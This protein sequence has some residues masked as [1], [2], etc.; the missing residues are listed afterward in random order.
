MIMKNMKIFNRINLG[1]VTVMA[2][3]L[4]FLIFFLLGSVIYDGFL[5][6]QILFNL[7]IDN[8]HLLIVAVGASLVLISGGIDLSIGAVLAFGS[9]VTAKLLLVTSLPVAV[10]FLIVLFVGIAFGALN[11]FLIT[12]AKFPAFIATLATQYLARGSCYIL[13][14]NTIAVSNSALIKIS[15]Y[16]IRLFVGPKGPF[17]SI[18]VIVSLIVF[19]IFEII[20]KHTNFGRGIYALGGNEQSAVL[21]GL[22]TKRIKML[23]YMLCGATSGV[24]S[25]VFTIYMLSAF[26]LSAESLHL[27]AVSAAVIGGVLTTGGVGI[28][29]GTLFGV[30]TTGV[31]QTIITFQ[32]TLSS[33]WTRIITAVLLLAFILL[34]RFV[35]FQRERSKVTKKIQLLE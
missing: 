7:F 31:I 2:A 30:L 19:V 6:T 5:S 25:I 8:A 13:D 10:I 11:G 1:N 22:P 12:Y 29:V 16:K 27:D 26:P 17:I 4:I 34:Q 15:L 32:G 18:G 33:W 35:V 24:A 14:S 3:V 21:M 28:M 23:V 9:M 20:S